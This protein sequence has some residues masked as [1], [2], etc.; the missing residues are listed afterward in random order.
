MVVMDRKD[1][2]EKSNSLLAQPAYRTIDM[3]PTNKLKAKLIT[4]F[5]RIKRA[6]GLEDSIHKYMY[7]MECASPKFYGLPK[8]HKTKTPLRPIVSSRGSVTYGVAEVLAK[9][10]MPLVSK[11]LHHIQSTKDFVDR[12]SKV[13]LQPGQYYW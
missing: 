1:Y 4:I 6:S 10:L 8:I 7:P 13:T 5:R 9:I 11:S 2:I 12:V 3:D